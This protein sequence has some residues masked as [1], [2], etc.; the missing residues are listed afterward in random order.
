MTCPLPLG[1]SCV[2]SSGKY[3]FEMFRNE[4]T[5]QLILKNVLRNLTKPTNWMKLKCLWCLNE[6]PKVTFEKKAH[7]IPKSLGGQ[8]YNINVCDECNSYFGNKQEA[9]YFHRCP[10]PSCSIINNHPHMFRHVLNH[11]RPLAM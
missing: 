11:H 3:R 10:Q 1:K 6:E 4:S 9:N 7:T 5:P 8:N 2:F